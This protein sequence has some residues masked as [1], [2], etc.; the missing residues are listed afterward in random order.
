MR[1]VAVLAALLVVAEAACPNQCSGN[2]FC[3]VTDK[4]VCFTQPGTKGSWRAMWTGADCSLRVCPYG[5]SFDM[6]SD[7]RQDLV[8][9]SSLAGATQD[10]A[11]LPAGV[12]SQHRLRAFTNGRQLLGRDAGVDVRVVSVDTANNR[13]RFQYKMSFLPTYSA[14]IVVSLNG[15]Y[16]SRA[17]AYHLTPDVN[18]NNGATASGIYV[19]FAVAQNDFAPTATVAA[20]DS[21]FFNVSYNEG[22]V[23]VPSDP[24]TALANAEC[25]SRGLC[26]RTKGQCTCFAGYTGDACQRTTC[27]ND[28]SGH[29]TCMSQKNFVDEGT[30]SLSGW[31]YTASD[32]TA[33]MG[34]KC[35]AGFRGA[36]C[37]Q[38][39][40][41]SGPD[42]LGGSGGSG[43]RDCSS[44]GDCDYTSGVCNCYKG[45]AGERCETQTAFV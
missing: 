11:F 23:F 21:Y 40:C 13:I 43:G 24:N 16:G 25:S 26:D 20:G 9:V 12:N 28:C 4:C 2:G 1:F 31:A 36:D 34:C 19:Y 10:V 30:L 22:Q 27:P 17:K 45:F 41:P 5:G 37:S 35:D 38:V 39:E 3:D 14:E 42:P 7:K 29:G 44:R 18:Q 6:V 33:Q 32:A 15:A 8:P